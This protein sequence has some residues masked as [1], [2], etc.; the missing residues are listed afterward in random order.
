MNSMKDFCD[1]DST[2]IRWF[3]MVAT[4]SRWSF[5]FRFALLSGSDKIYIGSEG[6]NED[7]RRLLFS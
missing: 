7:L 5:M 4:V 3:K 6:E 2:S 1:C